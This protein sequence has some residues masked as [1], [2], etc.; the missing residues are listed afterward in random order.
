MK[1]FVEWLYKP[2]L[3]VPDAVGLLRI[4]PNAE[5]YTDPFDLAVVFPVYEGFARIKGL[6]GTDLRPSHYRAGMEVLQSLGLKPWR[7]RIKR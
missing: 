5:K 4:G 1:A 3:I 7:E 2:P 6:S